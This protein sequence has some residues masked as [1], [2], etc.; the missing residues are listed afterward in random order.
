MACGGIIGTFKR[1]GIWGYVLVTTF[2]FIIGYFLIFHLEHLAAYSTVIF[3]IIFVVLHLFMHAGHGRHGGGS[4]IGG[5]FHGGYEEEE[6][7]VAQEKYSHEETIPP[8]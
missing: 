6:G 7:S 5:G 2:I 1:L 8:R 3:L 4:C